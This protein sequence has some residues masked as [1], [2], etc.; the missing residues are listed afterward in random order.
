MKVVTQNPLR[1]ENEKSFGEKKRK[2]E[3]VM[4]F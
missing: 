3:K 1:N 4:A 2:R